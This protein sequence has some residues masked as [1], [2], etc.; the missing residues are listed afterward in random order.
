MKI[1]LSVKEGDIV[2]LVSKR[3]S[4]ED[5]YWLRV[6]GLAKTF[7]GFLFSSYQQVAFAL[8]API[9]FDQAYDIIGMTMVSDSNFRSEVYGYMDN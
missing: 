8:T 5:S 7:P 9:S 1:A 4:I 2:W 6:W 3:G